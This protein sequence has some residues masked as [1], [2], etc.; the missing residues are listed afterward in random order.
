MNKRNKELLL[1]ML[2]DLSER[3][4]TDGCNDWEVPDD[5][6][7]KEVVEFQ[8][9]VVRVCQLDTDDAIIDNMDVLNYIMITVQNEI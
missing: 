8:K 6:S 1:S 9:D 5:W 2:E 7:D 3:Y 4:S